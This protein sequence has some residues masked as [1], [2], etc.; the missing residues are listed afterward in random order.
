MLSS[1][2]S[3]YTRNEKRFVRISFI[4]ICSLFLLILAGGIVR[5]TGAGMGCPDWPKC[6]DQWVPPTSEASLT[7]D[8][9]EQYLQKRIAKNERFANTL[10]TFGFSATA[11]ALRKDPSVM[12]VENFNVANTYTEYVNRLI[13]AVTGLLMVV[14]LW[15]AYLNRKTHLRVFLLTLLM[16]VL[17][18]FQ[19][20]FGS[21]VVSTNL[22]SWTITVHMVVAFIILML[23]ISAHS[24]VKYNNLETGKINISKLR[25]ATF[26][27]WLLL[28]LSFLQ[29]IFGTELRE[30]IDYYADFWQGTNRGQWVKLAGSIFQLHRSFSLVLLMLGLYMTWF[31]RIHFGAIKRLRRFSSA[32]FIFMLLQMLSGLTL[33]N[34]GLPAFMQPVHLLLAS[35]LIAA[36]WMQIMMIEV[37][38][39]NIALELIS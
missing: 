20:W 30:S 11:E 13:G 25:W 8:Y 3:E 9:R 31:V 19:G 16:L 2:R 26:Y 14:M 7:I 1:Y 29:V 10:Q 21:I 12:A 34:F 38:K 5:S 36:L 27:G 22:V 23:A 39:R 6:F 18:L 4:T 33:S 32:A 37:Y 28:V 24:M 17:T 35:L 15:F